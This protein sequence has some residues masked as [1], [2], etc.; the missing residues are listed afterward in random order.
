MHNCKVMQKVH[1]V[2]SC[3]ILIYILFTILFYSQKIYVS[4]FFMRIN[5]HSKFL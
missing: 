4:E 2:K 3:I 5:L 1:L